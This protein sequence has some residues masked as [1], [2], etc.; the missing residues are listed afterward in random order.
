MGVGRIVVV[1]DVEGEESKEEKD[2]E[3]EQG[4]ETEVR[5]AP[6]RFGRGR[7]DDGEDL[8]GWEGRCGS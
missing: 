5:E 1:L 8:L 6:A 2:E 7:R 3:D 4:E